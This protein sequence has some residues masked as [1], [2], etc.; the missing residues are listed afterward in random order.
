YLGRL[1]P[2]EV[3][4]QPEVWEVLR[5]LDAQLRFPGEHARPRHVYFW[6]IQAR[7][8]EVEGERRQPVGGAR[9]RFVRELERSLHPG[10]EAQ[11]CQCNT[12]LLACLTLA[13]RQLRPV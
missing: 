11:A 9:L 1:H 12:L 3:R 13:S 10:K 6:P 2:G 4:G 8:R 5:L 7:S